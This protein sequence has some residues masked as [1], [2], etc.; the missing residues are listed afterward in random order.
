MEIGAVTMNVVEALKLWSAVAKAV[1][2]TVLP[3]I[4]GYV[5]FGKGTTNIV[6]T[7]GA[8]CVP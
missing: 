3:T 2:V 7:P 5:T 4:M 1:S 8:E 6:E